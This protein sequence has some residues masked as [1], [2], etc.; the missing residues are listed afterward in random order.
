[1]L[2]LNNLSVTPKFPIRTSW[3]KEC[4]VGGRVC[5]FLSSFVSCAT[6]HVSL[7]PSRAA[8]IHNHVLQ[9]STC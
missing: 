6:C 4:K 2:P 5:S 8:G 9:P 3:W 7:T 1:M